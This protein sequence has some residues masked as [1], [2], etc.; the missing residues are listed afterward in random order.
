MNLLSGQRVFLIKLLGK[1]WKVCNVLV[2][3]L[4][5]VK[6]VFFQLCSASVSSIKPRSQ[7]RSPTALDGFALSKTLQRRLR[8]PV[9]LQK[10]RPPALVKT[11]GLSGIAEGTARTMSHCGPL[12]QYLFGLKGEIPISSSVIPQ[13]SVCHLKRIFHTPSQKSWIPDIS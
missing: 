3:A 10:V 5:P 6:H 9:P 11:W 12:P 7:T 4:L 2:L 13:R 1:G 8:W